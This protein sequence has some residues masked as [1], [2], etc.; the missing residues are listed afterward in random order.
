[1]VIPLHLHEKQ[2]QVFPQDTKQ[3]KIFQKFGHK[4]STY[5]GIISLNCNVYE[6]KKKD[7]VP[8]STE[9][10]HQGTLTSQIICNKFFSIIFLFSDFKWASLLLLCLSMHYLIFYRLMIVICKKMNHYLHN[11]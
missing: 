8:E 11:P 7:P 6:L 2:K 3:L 10:V 1:M 9:Y 4:N 5:V